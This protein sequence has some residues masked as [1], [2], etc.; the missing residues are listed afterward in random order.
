MVASK[1]LMLRFSK[2][3][4]PYR[5]LPWQAFLL[6][7][8]MIMVA[9][10]VVADVVI[11]ELMVRPV[12]TPEPVDEE[13]VELFNTGTT[14]VDVSG[15]QLNRGVRFTIP[16]GTSISAGGI[17]VLAANRD[18]LIARSPNAIS[19][20]EGGWSGKLSNSGERVRL[21]DATGTTIDQVEYADEGDWAQRRPG[22]VLSG[23]RGWVWQAPHDDDG[24]S[25]ELIDAL[26]R[27]DRGQNWSSSS[28]PGGT[29]GTM[30]SIASDNI[31]PLISKVQHRPAV[32]APADSV[33]VLARI[34]DRGTEDPE[35]TLH[36]RIAELSASSG[37]SLQR[38]FEQATM[39][40]DGKHNDNAS[41]DGLYAAILPPQSDGTIVEFF[42]EASDGNLSRTWPAPS[43]E[44]GNHDANALYRVQ[45][46][47][48]R[49]SPHD[50]ILLVMTPD[51]D[52]TF[53]NIRRSSNALMNTSVVWVTENGTPEIRYQCGVRVRGNSSRGSNPHP[54]RLT[55]PEDEPIDNRTEFNINSKSSYLQ[56]L[57][58]HLF[59]QAGLP[60]P[61]AR[62]MQLFYNGRNRANRSSPMFGHYAMLEP[63]GDEFIGREIPDSAGNLYK[64]RSAS[65]SRDRK[66]WGVHFETS[67]VY[68]NA[69]WY[70][71]DRWE[72]QTNVSEDDW[73]DLQQFVEVMHAAP[74]ETFLSEA[75]A[76]IN[77]QQWLRWFA[78]MT[79]FN[80][81]ETNLSNGID[82]DY[83]IYRGIDDPRFVLLPHDFDSIFNFGADADETIFPMIE[84]VGGVSGADEI[85]QLIRYMRS[86]EIEREYFA[87]LD[88]LLHTILSTERF[89]STVDQLLG[90]WVTSG[91]VRSI[92]N[93]LEA[94]R[95][96][97]AEAIAAKPVEVD[98]SGQET[99][100]FA[101]T[102]AAA[103]NLS[104]AFD[105]TVHARITVAG[106]DA[107][108]NLVRDQW[109]IDSASL[110]PGVNR[111]P[112]V[113][114]A[115]DGT[116]A[117]AT[118]IDIWR[119]GVEATPLPEL[120][121]SDLTLTPE[122]G[123][124]LASGVVTVAAN[125][126]L[127]I[128]PGTSL[129][130]E[131]EAQ[132]RVEGFLKAEGTKNRRIRFTSVPG[133][134]QVE[135]IRPELPLSQP[136]WAGIRFERSI[137]PENIIRFADIEYAQDSQGAI[138]LE[139]SEA[140]IDQCTFR[141]SRLRY[142]H[143]VSSSATISNC[144]FPDM[145]LP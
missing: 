43:D 109:S 41:G 86:P 70:R 69:N 130:F 97:V 106:I 31:A 20:I 40:D 48:D 120:I 23:T 68:N 75:D 74:D 79:I 110:F 112:I 18:A 94:R 62:P 108:L 45:L 122:T 118:F 64:K 61:D 10:R 65:P 117:D 136:H 81:R 1:T 115:H 142:I 67:V 32:P 88:E 72:K 104:G 56:V 58:M 125:I 21:S 35:V 96:F 138:H 33:T 73:S 47:E 128:A 44:N 29:P 8:V 5:F 85:P 36:Y 19:I 93:S 28:E 89:N 100:E 22:P 141:G 46:A 126:T 135:D 37:N 116:E 4:R 127:T 124:H 114:F 91:T 54:I 129:F 131:P 144:R 16:A 95:E 145:F 50:A 24:F 76:V 57:G 49:G 121:G 30:N 87:Q 137:S 9:N 38:Q 107:D 101:S 83:S 78:M 27:N 77:R 113:A 42:V 105:S 25:L 90:S 3:F 7:L 111:I 92:K 98:W 11:S 12:G 139:R 119:T 80:N 6:V 82:D 34:E 143:S 59:S 103:T 71:T 132:L 123:P 53:T 26:S 133:A 15:W 140:V 66:R 102:D 17:L 84:R 63:L 60:A 99:G 13:F 39:V 2:P 52:R 14:L 134:E 51:D 55:V